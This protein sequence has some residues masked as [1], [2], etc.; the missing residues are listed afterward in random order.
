MQLGLAIVSC[1][2]WRVVG[3]RVKI[4]QPKHDPFKYTGHGLAGHGLVGLEHEAIYDPLTHLFIRVHKLAGS[5]VRFGFMGPKFR[6]LSLKH[7]NEN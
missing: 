4:C 1:S 3:W 7:P 2:G 5:W 6:Y